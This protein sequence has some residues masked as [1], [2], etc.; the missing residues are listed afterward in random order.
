MNKNPTHLDA[1]LLE[2]EPIADELAFAAHEA[3]GVRGRYSTFEFVLRLS[4]PIHDRL[5]ALP[6]GI[7]SKSD[8]SLEDA[9]AFS[10]YLHETIHWWQHVGS[11]YGLILSTTYPAESH[12]NHG[13]LKR[14]SEQI[15][16]K[17]PIRKLA[18][19]L[20]GS[21]TPD[22]PA[23]QANIIINNQFDFDAFRRITF[24]P[25]SR[26]TIATSP[27]FESIGHAM[28]MTYGNVVHLLAS[29]ADPKY[30]ALP[31]PSSWHESVRALRDAQQEGY[32]YGSPVHVYPIGSLHI[33]E[34]Q[35]RF[36]QIQ[37]LYFTSDRNLSWEDFHSVGML[38]A[39]VYRDAFEFFLT[40]AGLEWPERIDDPVIALFLLVCDMA[41]NPGAGFPFPVR[42]PRSFIED[43]DPGARFA[44]LA[45]AVH[46]LCPEV[47]LAIKNYSFAEYE[48]VSEK[49]AE[50]LKID[51]PLA[52]AREVA[53]WPSRSEGL[54]ALALERESFDFDPTNLPIR[55]MLSHFVA[56][57]ADKAERPE[58]FCWPGAWTTGERVSASEA[59]LFEKHSAL[60]AD[61]PGN[62][63][64][65]PRL[66]PDKDETLVQSTFQTFFSSVSTYD[67]TRQW[68]T[69]SGPFRFQYNWLVED[70]SQEDM[71]TF[72]SRNFESIYGI[73]PDAFEIL[74][75]SAGDS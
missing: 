22:T 64:V 2:S 38:S 70:A 60:F 63:G 53:S 29:V 75:P 73:S 27:M 41:I 65:F 37:Y 8:I 68:I 57:M 47:A 34:G 16:F 62:N 66:Q 39:G 44:F 5:A 51:S 50:V 20:G 30:L 32:Y 45:Y 31:D 17:K 43:V 40:Q 12:A 72:G 26:Q 24:S 55:V 61:K 71:K 3:S 19:L 6:S 48:E 54:A 7:V 58:F 56:F 18:E 74:D 33:M 9:E 35:A 69:E 59:V 52:I 23:G 36:A 21:S 46:K 14:L 1:R 4:Q 25:S 67:L 13:L 49:L 15:G 11:T 10:V 42:Y 28:R